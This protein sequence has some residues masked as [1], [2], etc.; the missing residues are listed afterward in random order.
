[1]TA[2]SVVLAGAVLGTVPAS[3]VS[4]GTV[5]P[6]GQLPQVVKVSLEGKACSGVVVGYRWVLTAANCFPGN[7]FGGEPVTPA[8]VVVDSAVADVVGLVRREDRD[9]MLAELSRNVTGALPLSDVAVA[10]GGSVR[11]AGFGRTATE[12]VSD[13]PSAATFTVTASS[14][15]TLALAGVDGRDLC[16]GDAGGPVLRDVDGSPQVVG[17]AGTSWQ[18]GCLGAAADVRQGSTATRVDDIAGWIRETVSPDRARFGA[19][20]QHGYCMEVADGRTEDGAAIRYADCATTDDAKQ[21]FTKATDGTLRVMGKCLDAAG[22]AVDQVDRRVRLWT[23]DGSDQQK[24]TETFGVKSPWNN[25]C[26][27]W[28]TIAAGTAVTTGGCPVGNIYDPILPIRF[29]GFGNLVGEGSQCLDV[30]GGRTEEG[31]PLRNAACVAPTY[32]ATGSRQNIT[33]APDGSLRVFDKCLDAA[34]SQTSGV[35][36]LRTCNG[37]SQQKWQIRANRNIVSTW[38]SLCLRATTTENAT[39]VQCQAVPSQQWTLRAP[40]SLPAGGDRLVRGE[41]L[42]ADQS[43]YSPDG[44]TRLTMQPDGNLVLYNA[45]GTVLWHTAT[46]GT[47]ATFATLQA[48]GNFVVYTA[49]RQPVWQTHTYNSAAQRLVVQTD[50]NLA[51][52]G[53][54]ATVFWHRMQ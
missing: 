42:R 28:R 54:D 43:K 53:P 26:L 13:R 41:E 9:V 11:A 35:V 18:H 40:A 23:C 31:A 30:T 1:M 37:S 27:N 45:A 49:Q 52:Y 44:R 38:N 12:W 46:Y 15:T 33:A 34:G 50:T 24:W 2:A 29:A 5:V 32:L 51:L 39:T 14:T 16:K 21:R 7:P 4:G 25:K 8:K 10:T 19:I 17:I 6:N 47:G 20:V 3:A 22:A 48:D 36:G